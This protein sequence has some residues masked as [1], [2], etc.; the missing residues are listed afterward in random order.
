MKKLML[1]LTLLLPMSVINANP[2]GLCPEDDNPPFLQ[3][4]DDSNCSVYYLCFEGIP[5]P[6]ECGIG[7]LYD[8]FQ[9]TCVI[10]EQFPSGCPCED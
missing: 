4:P 1:I 8:C 7:F 2:V 3:L 9:A 10:A 5:Y 6:Q